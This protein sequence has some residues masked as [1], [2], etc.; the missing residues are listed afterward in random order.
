MSR[1]FIEKITATFRRRRY[2]IA[3]GNHLVVLCAGG[4]RIEGDLIAYCPEGLHVACDSADVW[5]NSEAIAAVVRVKNRDDG[6]GSGGDGRPPV[7]NG[8]KL[9]QP[10]ADGN[11]EMRKVFCNGTR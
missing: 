1:H 2:R 10:E 4:L 11:V 9:R 3:L 6:G 8:V 7:G 5:V